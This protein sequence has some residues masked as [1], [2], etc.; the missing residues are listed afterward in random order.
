MIDTPDDARTD[1][2]PSLGTRVRQARRK[3]GFTGR[4]LARRTGVSPSMISHIEADRQRPSTRTLRTLARE[5]D[6][7]LA[8]LE[9]A[10]DYRIDSPNAMMSQLSAFA[11][12]RSI[13]ALTVQRG[14]ERRALRLD[15]GVTWELLTKDRD[16][17]IDFLQTTYEVG[18]SPMSNGVMHRHPGRDYGY[19]LKGRIQVTVGFDA[20][21]ILE[22]G[23]LIVLDATVP[24]RS[25]NIGSEP[26]TVIWVVLGSNSSLAR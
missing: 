24:H 7:P 2:R 13:P 20:P 23:D 14:D 26:A 1:D 6:L 19:V 3:R 5:L 16:P 17:F 9:E 8:E 12:L 10:A 22:A 11:E 4:E 21:V 15:S 18:G 25:E